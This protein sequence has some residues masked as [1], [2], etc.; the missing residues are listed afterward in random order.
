MVE[1]AG[2]PVFGVLL[3]PVLVGYGIAF[4]HMLRS[5]KL[6]RA[7][8]RERRIVYPNRVG[9]FVDQHPKSWLRS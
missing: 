6:R 2:I 4:R 8:Q 3:I 9:G 5:L 7:E 1:R